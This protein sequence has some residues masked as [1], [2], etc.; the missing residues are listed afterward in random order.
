MAIFV[1]YL[2]VIWWFHTSH[3]II[4]GF[5]SSTSEQRNKRLH[6]E[7][8]PSELNESCKQKKQFVAFIINR[9]IGHCRKECYKSWPKK[10][11]E[12]LG[13]HKK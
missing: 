8:F 11:N 6:D 12:N 10:R 4:S 2:A 13:L 1:G 7:K 5:R 3:N 9:N